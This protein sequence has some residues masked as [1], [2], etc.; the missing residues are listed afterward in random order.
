MK[1]YQVT[2]KLKDF[3]VIKAL[4]ASAFPGS[5]YVPMTFLLRRAKRNTINFNAYYDEDIF[6][7]FAYTVTLNDLTYLFVFAIQSDIRSKG[8]GTQILNLIKEAYPTNRIVLNMLALDPKASDNEQRKRREKFYLKN[9]YSFADFSCEMNGNKLVVLFQNKTCTPEEFLA[10]FKE[11]WGPILF[12]FF[13]PKIMVS[14][15]DN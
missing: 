10:I 7:G 8:Y 9:G 4:H 12:A 6:V 5:Q 3:Q 11:F 13:K 1:A 14:K 15:S 2:K